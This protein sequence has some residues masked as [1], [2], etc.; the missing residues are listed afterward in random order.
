MQ[1]YKHPLH[2][3]IK[4]IQIT[5]LKEKMLSDYVKILYKVFSKNILTGSLKVFVMNFTFLEVS[6]L[7]LISFLNMQIS[8][9][10]IKYVFNIFQFTL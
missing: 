5:G 4:Y 9:S 8:F 2:K 1:A 10:T 3:S 6:V 7:S